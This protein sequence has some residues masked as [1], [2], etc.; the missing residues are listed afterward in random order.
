MKDPIINHINNNRE[1]FDQNLPDGL[2]WENVN[3][4]LHPE[5]KNRKWLWYKIAA[6]FVVL[7]GFGYLLTKEDIQVDPSNEI[8]ARALASDTVRNVIRGGSWKDVGWYMQTAPGGFQ[9]QDNAKSYIGYR[10]VTTYLGRGDVSYGLGVEGDF[11]WT[12]GTLDANELAGGT[13]TVTVM[14]VNGC[15]ATEDVDASSYVYSWNVGNA[16][17]GTLE[18]QGEPTTGEFI[19][20]N[21]WGNV[22]KE[23]EFKNGKLYNGSLHIYDDNGALLKTEEYK[24]GVFDSYSYLSPY[25]NPG[26]Y[27]EQYDQFD[28]NEFISPLSEPLSTF[29]IDVD[30]AGYSNMR[31]YVTDGYLP[32]KDAIK[33]EE[34]INY[35][36]YDLPEPS[37]DHPF[38]ITT[39]VGNCPWNKRN[40]LV[41]IC[42]KG[43]TVPKEDLPP[44][45]L[46]FLL[47]V[48][49]SMED[50]NKL[51]LLKQGFEMLVKELRPED[52][53]SIV[54]YAGS[55]GVVL[56]P[57]A[58]NK[59][60][61]IL[62]ALNNLSAGGSTAGG[63]G[64]QLAYKLA[65]E[66]FDKDGN[67]RI[68][69]ATDGDFNVGMSDDDALVELIE[70]K[71]DGGVFLSVLGFGEGNLQ[72]SKMEKIADNGNG[73]Y[74]YIDNILEAKKVLVSEFGGTLYTI[75]KDVKLQL[76]F[77]P[78][79]VGSYRLLGYENRLLAPEDFEDD[80]KDAG[81][82]GS[83]HTVVAF[84]ELTPASK[85]AGKGEDLK[86]QQV[87]LTDDH[88][89]EEELMTINF[90]YKEPTGTKS[91]L[92]TRVVGG[93]VTEHPSQNFQFASA[94]AEFGL[95]IRESDY[96]GTANFEDL[97]DRAKYNKGVDLNGYRSEFVKLAE[98]AELLWEDYEDYQEELSKLK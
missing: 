83:G 66:Y 57:T 27:Y 91:K 89:V 84:Y 36:N 81:D 45:N 29:G 92:I 24:S 41:Q 32:P 12:G 38:S 59:T 33:L 86:Y 73:N 8:A 22:E 51:P 46:V 98:M 31:R 23:G 40:K 56:P 54:T 76:E 61:E 96:R 26:Y 63:E 2:V 14:D 16:N 85:N 13:Y 10:N 44:S 69:L 21:E 28:E 94:V 74:S 78:K 71:R 37:G 65:D 47:D 3:K 75:A 88:R 68:I 60:E 55:A 58:G 90:R 15:V 80:A 39:E 34:M 50:A 17:T 77:N 93:K 9:Y 6:V 70:E 1:E 97:I 19:T 87:T 11:K 52:H 25:E 4:A 18:N 49:G 53:V 42:I 48:S 64:I 43:K 20:Y 30:G 79:E 72:S 62:Q 82:L 7:L 67:N 5:E 35:F 95:L